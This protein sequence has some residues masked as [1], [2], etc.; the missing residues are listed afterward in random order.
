MSKKLENKKN[1]AIDD[2][3]KVDDVKKLVEYFENTK[4][5]KTLA[6]NHEPLD[7]NLKNVAKDFN[8]TAS[9]SRGSIDLKDRCKYLESRAVF[10]PGKRKFN[11][12]DEPFQLG[13]SQTPKKRRENRL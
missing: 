6:E 10:S 4:N 11:F 8:F 3:E 7:L 13:T 1:V 12:S 5:V 9:A 2:D